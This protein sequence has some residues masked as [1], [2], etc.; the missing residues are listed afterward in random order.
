MFI[1]TRRIEGLRNVAEAARRAEA[2]LVPILE[3]SKGFK[4]YH[5]VDGSDG[6]GLSVALFE[7]RGD[8]E[9]IRD[10]A[11]A[12][13]KANLADLHSGEPVVTAGEVIFSA[14]P[15]AAAVR[16]A[17]AKGAELRPH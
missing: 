9:R 7:S 8:A 1:V 16:P 10:Q 2:G 5:I 6:V 13:V 15:G 12:W 11:M 4:G 17:A 3:Q 14:R